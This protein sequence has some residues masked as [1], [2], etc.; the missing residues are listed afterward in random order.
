MRSVFVTA[1]I[2]ISLSI[3]VVPAQKP[4]SIAK[5]QTRTRQARVVPLPAG[6]GKGTQAQ[7]TPFLRM[8]LAPAG[9]PLQKLTGTGQGKQPLL[10]GLADLQLRPMNPLIYGVST[11]WDD[12]GAA[13]NW[14]RSSRARALAASLKG[15]AAT[16]VR[17]DIRW[18]EIENSRGKYDWAAS[19]AIVRYVGSLGLT[20]VC[21]VS[22][23][24]DW[25]LDPDARALFVSRGMLRLS[26]SRAPSTKNYPDLNRFATAL[27]S[28]YHDQIK[29]W[30]FWTEPDGAGMPVVV[31]DSLG[32]AS[33]IRFTG[34]A[35]TY[36]DMLR[37]FS[38]GVKRAD[39][40]ARI[41]VGGLQTAS[42]DFLRALYMNSGQPFFDAVA[43]HPCYERNAVNF[44]WIDRCHDLMIKQGD[45]AKP[46]WL[47]EWGWTTLPESANGITHQHQ[48]QLVKECL[49]G[50]RD[51]PFIEQ[52]SYRALNDWRANQQ[53]PLSLMS[54]GLTTYALSPKPAYAVFRDLATGTPHADDR[55]FARV[56]LTGALP[57]NGLGSPV[58]VTINAAK[59]GP[60]ITPA[61]YGVNQSAERGGPDFVAKM[62]ARLRALGV[63][64]VR[65]DPLPSP[66][67]VKRESVVSAALTEK[68]QDG[69]FV[70]DWRY[71]DDM[72]EAIQ[73]AGAKPMITFSTMPSALSAPTGNVRMPKDMAE[74]SAF[75]RSV[76]RHFN[77]EQKRG[78]VYWE[79]GQEPNRGDYTLDEWLR[80]YDSFARAVVS[81]DS[82]AKVGGP[83]LSGMD[84][85]WV[86]SFLKHCA[87]NSTPLHF[88]S[89]HA[90]DKSPAE[91]K[92][93]AD[94][95]N[96]AAKDAG[97][98]SIEPILAEWNLSARPTLDH[99]SLSGASCVL[100]TLSALSD[101]GVKTMMY[102]LKEGRTLREN[103]QE[104]A[105]RWGLLTSE[106]NP[107]PVFHALSLLNRVAGRSL[108]AN[109]EDGSIHTLAASG[110]GGKVWALVWRDDR[111]SGG[112]NDRDVPV[113]LQ[114]QGLP[115][116]GDVAG[117]CM[118]LEDG[119]ADPGSL[120]RKSGFRTHGANVEIPIVLGR[121]NIALVELAGASPATVD[122]N[123]ATPKYQVFAGE[124]FPVT[125]TLKNKG[126]SPH[127]I[128][129][130][131]S[132]SD[133]SLI[134]AS[135]AQ[136]KT[137]SV[138]PGTSRTITYK[139]TAPAAS[140]HQETVRINTDTGGSASVAVKVVAPFAARLDPAGVDVPRSGGLPDSLQ[141]TARARVFLLNRTEQPMRVA[142]IAG[143]G[144]DS[145][146]LAAGE[147][148]TA[149]VTLSPPSTEPGNYTLPVRVLNGQTSLT[150]K[151]RVGVPAIARYVSHRPRLVGEPLD[152]T[153]AVPID[154][155]GP[156]QG[157][158]RLWKGVA[159]LSA[160]AHILW[161]E[162]YLYV[163]VGVNDD[164]DYH[165][166]AAQDMA[167]ADSVII[168]LSGRR[169]SDPDREGF[170]ASDLEFGI[171]GRTGGAPALYL[172]HA[173]ARTAQA[174][175]IRCA[176][177]RT[178]GRTFYEAAI[179]WSAIE[180]HVSDNDAVGLA[181]LVNDSDGDVRNY[182][183]WGG[184]LAGEKRPGKFFG[185][186]LV[187]ER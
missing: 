143:R 155:P 108:P 48:A 61:L 21:T 144:T 19:D 140:D 148:A 107:K 124:P 71:A 70:I 119:C 95:L 52:A 100:T 118:L 94:T 116:K 179:P 164:V 63:K 37:A 115:F 59:P 151:A 175:V 120:P 75:V 64:L 17:I 68:N 54:D 65:F 159:D 5:K 39:Q 168:G 92:Q 154:M 125:V 93:Q 167:K 24:P 131:L 174:E 137:Y 20:T 79:L 178:E 81:V 6:F 162:Q 173:P 183:E 51:R 130:D 109:S 133:T 88:V 26:Q 127:K 170:S 157:R 176:V 47:T 87:A 74:W 33:D 104:F 110:E 57:A 60:E 147:S 55:T 165:P 18:S 172:F 25:A 113:T 97:F 15:I 34:D 84:D 123:V 2:F 53:D 40:A 111:N 9:V 82:T 96:A 10:P 89:W 73:A 13:G 35:R 78:I 158:D 43:L 169:D 186:R 14:D 142:I 103:P 38:T 1:A 99:D 16:N 11:N 129:M 160:R 163:A 42:P 177:K 145:V 49:T 31:R 135:L 58:Q 150:L 117:S 4:G 29:M 152:W 56:A 126:T 83:S 112:V 8:S 121:N 41:C 32:R 30:E 80:L 156:P 50:M 166:F 23:T 105:G 86:S 102:E 90:Y 106:D 181:I 114:V 62:T 72:T 146:T 128:V 182:L 3:S 69:P 132:D 12:A 77:Q 161:D 141:A 27:A 28:R 46:I 67:M 44:D 101:A 122:L 7:S 22:G 66:D 187:R 180:R 185:V 76:V 134:P 45:A 171:M 36:A 153:D 149:P 184:G 139:I 85:E 91:I 138:Q 98:A 136:R